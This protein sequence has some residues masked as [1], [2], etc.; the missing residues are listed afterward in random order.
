MTAISATLAHRRHPERCRVVVISRAG[1]LSVPSGLLDG[2]DV[3]FLQRQDGPDPTAA[4]SLLAG[5]DVLACTNACLPVLDDQLL[6]RLPYL[7]HVV[8]YATGYEQVDLDVLRR[9]GVGLSVLPDYATVAVAEHALAMLFS[10]AARVHLAHDRSRGAVPAT[11]SLRGVELGSRTLGIIGTGRIGTQ[12]AAMA[13][14]VGMRVLGTDIDSLAAAR[15]GRRGVAMVGQ[16]GLLRDSDVVVL[17]ASTVRGA[18]PVLDAAA[19]RALRP[20]ALVVNVGRP[21][22]VDTAAMLAAVRGGWV[23]GYGVDDVVIDASAAVEDLALVREGRVLQ[24]GH[25]AWWRDEVLER[26]AT[27]FGRAIAAA[28][29]GCPVDVVTQVPGAIDVGMAGA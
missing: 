14:G 21:G 20:G 2:V 22:L 4:A 28:V 25:S 5:V 18:G 8:L 13:S 17:C 7:R 1:R 9:H 3:R 23:R 19:I 11:T 15:A 29:A 26:G 16:P 12:L 10:L 24:T 27:M 6:T